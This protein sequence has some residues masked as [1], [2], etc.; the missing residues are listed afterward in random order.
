MLK[1]TGVE[2]ELF[3][4]LEMYTMVEGAKRSGMVQATHRYAKANNKYLQPSGSEPVQAEGK[5]NH[6]EIP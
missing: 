2:L 6:F 3:S 4:V 1:F 5:S